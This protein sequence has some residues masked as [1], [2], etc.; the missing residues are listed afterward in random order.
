PDRASALERRARTRQHSIRARLRRR[1]RVPARDEERTVAVSRGA[2]AA[3]ARRRPVHAARD[4]RRRRRTRRRASE[5]RPGV[6]RLEDRDLTEPH[7]DGSELYVDRTGDS[8]ELRVRVPDGGAD[9]VLLRYLKDGEPRMVE[10]TVASRGHG[11]VWWRA[12]VPLRSPLV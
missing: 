12:E 1:D 5:R 10:A 4:P 6:P 7:H 2:G 3:R 9:A 8:A 11:E